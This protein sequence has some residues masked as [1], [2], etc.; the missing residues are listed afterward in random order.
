MK[1]LNVIGL[2]SG[3]LMFI[4][5]NAYADDLDVT[6][7]VMD[8]NSTAV[9]KLINP[10]ELPTQA[11]DKAHE[12]ASHGLDTANAARERAAERMDANS[13]SEDAGDNVSDH[14]DLAGDNANE[15][16]ANASDNAN[17]HA[18]LAADNAS[19]R[20]AAASDNANEHAALA[21]DNANE[22]AAAAGDNANEH[23]ALAADNANDRAA[24]ARANAGR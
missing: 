7:D 5:V 1:T 10:I 8:S 9:D 19:E 12:K 2:L 18:A 13:H 23:A 6:M 16:A 3:A 15:M 17:E 14:A 21:A 22:M 11:S 20:A 4:A 24:S